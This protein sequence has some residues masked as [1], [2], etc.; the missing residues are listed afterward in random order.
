MS[1]VNKG[2]KVISVNE[3]CQCM[4][5]VRPHKDGWELEYF[6]K[7]GKPYHRVVSDNEF[8]DICNEFERGSKFK[9]VK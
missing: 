5:S 4:V 9:G 8:R 7:F 3:A 2:W 6:Y 1:E